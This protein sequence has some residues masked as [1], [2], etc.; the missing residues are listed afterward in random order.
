MPPR[1]SLVVPHC[2]KGIK[3]IE[4]KFKVGRVRLL[5]PIKMVVLSSPPLA[6]AYSVTP[7]SK[8]DE[9]S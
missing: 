7:V 5:L 6:V 9:Y 3:N 4:I 8:T 1:S 2:I